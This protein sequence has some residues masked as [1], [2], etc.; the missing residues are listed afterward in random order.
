MP[1]D[2]VPEADQARQPVTG[3]R[4]V[5][6]AEGEV[7][8]LTI[9]AEFADCKFAPGFKEELEDQ[10]FRADTPESKDDP[11]YPKESLRGYYQRSSFGK[12]DITGE[13]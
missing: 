7:K 6:P 2:M 8:T 12:L 10:L 11:L 1:E 9:L 13:F 4:P 3:L 5:M